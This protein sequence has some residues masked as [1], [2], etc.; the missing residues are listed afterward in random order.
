VKDYGKRPVWEL[1]G[2]VGGYQAKGVVRTD[3]KLKLAIFEAVMTINVEDF[4]PIH[5]AAESD[6]AGSTQAES[7]VVVRVEAEGGEA[8][9]TVVSVPRGRLA[10]EG[11]SER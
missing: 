8:Q 7:G 10:V 5:G 6:K 11:R 4:H 1:C 9:C 3:G 2:A